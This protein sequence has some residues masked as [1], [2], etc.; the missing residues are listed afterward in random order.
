MK[1]SKVQYDLWRIR[2]RLDRKLA[3]MTPEQVQQYFDDVDKRVE[4]KL[5]RPLGLRVEPATMHREGRAVPMLKLYIETSVWSHWF[6]EDAPDR[7]EATR[8]LLTRCRDSAGRISM[9]ISAFVM[10][11]VRDAP[12]K[13]AARLEAL[14]AELRPRMQDPPPGV[15]ELARSYAD[16]GALPAGKPADRLHVAI[17]TVAEMDILVSWNYRHLVNV[18][19]RAKISAVNNLAGHWKPLQIATPFEVLEDEVQQETD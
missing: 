3:K 6:A 7:R 12:G 17:A 11:E 15:D 8:E 4:A 13:L 1:Y 14:I 9:Y 10:D 19:R 2:A 5:G 18:G 16:L